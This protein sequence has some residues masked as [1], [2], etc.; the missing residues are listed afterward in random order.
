VEIVDAKGNKTWIEHDEGPA[1]VNYDKIPKPRPAF[2]VA[3]AIT[4]ANA[5]TL[6]DGACVEM[7]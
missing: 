4:A 2:D 7:I 3:G 5:S 6:N 1:R